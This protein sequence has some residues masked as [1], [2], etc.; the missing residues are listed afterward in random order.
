MNAREVVNRLKIVGEYQVNVQHE[1]RSS[2]GAHHGP[3]YAIV[4][5]RSSER[6]PGCHAASLP[7]ARRLI[8]R[9]MDILWIYDC[10]R[11][12]ARPL[13]GS[14]RGLTSVE[15]F[16]GASHAPQQAATQLWQLKC[17]FIVVCLHL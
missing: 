14:L 3:L 5:A 15:C 17:F 1:S 8:M 11:C 13:A 16:G 4:L 10:I 6:T 2:T 7:T 12:L 9:L